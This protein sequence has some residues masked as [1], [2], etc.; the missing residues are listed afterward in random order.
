MATFGN[1][2]IGTAESNFEDYILG[3]KYTMGAADG[4]G[5][6]I[7]A[8]LKTYTATSNVKACIYNSDK[9]LL[10]AT[11]ERDDC[12]ANAWNT[13]TFPDPKPNLTAD[14]DY[15]LVIWSGGNVGIAAQSGAPANSHWY[16]ADLYN[17]WPDPIGNPTSSYYRSIYCNYTVAGEDLTQELSDTLSLSESIKHDIGVHPSD[18][19]GLSEDLASQSEFKLALADTLALSESIASDIAVYLSDTLDLSEDLT[20]EVTAAVVKILRKRYIAGLKP[21]RVVKA[22]RIGI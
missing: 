11:V 8:Y 6:D 14:A 21:A 1:T 18:T 12:T 3:G 16:I 2:A 22:G 13:F 7:T 20:V 4:V 5:D 10:K 15:I 17:G 19:L 9:T